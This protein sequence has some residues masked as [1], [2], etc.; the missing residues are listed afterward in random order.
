MFVAH[1]K[2][3]SAW[4]RGDQSFQSTLRVSPKVIFHIYVFLKFRQI[5]INFILRLLQQTLKVL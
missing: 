5:N 2:N 4:Y 1:N 3:H